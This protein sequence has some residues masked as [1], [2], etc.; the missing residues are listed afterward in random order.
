MATEIELKAWVDDPEAL[1]A[2]I[3]SLACFSASFDK[4]DA[5]WYPCSHCS[6]APVPASGVRI[7]KET[8]TDDTG[9]VTHNIGVTY[10]LKEVRDGIEVNDERE[11]SVS[12][13]PVFEE[14]LKRL[15]LQ[16]GAIKHKHGWAW[17]YE[18]ITV[19]LVQI[20]K[21]GWFV[22]LE[23]MADNDHL[24]TVLSARTR[25]LTFLHYLDIGED[26]IE[27]RYYT[28]MLHHEKV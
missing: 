3:A 14:L 10:K 12:D 17:Q 1:K 8:A 11:F 5:Y 2:R 19:E 22:E 21:L 6:A 18:G 24:E 26:K 23:I 15:G 25:L 13:G 9:S 27:T 16:C 28:E 4:E 20:A 7:R